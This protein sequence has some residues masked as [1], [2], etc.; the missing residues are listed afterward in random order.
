MASNF[1]INFGIGTLGLDADGPF[2]CDPDANVSDAIFKEK[3][4]KLRPLMQPIK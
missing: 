3:V 4:P 1:E 2:D